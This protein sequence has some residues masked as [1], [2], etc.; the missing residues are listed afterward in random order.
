MPRIV[1]DQ[2]R[3]HA[4]A[5]RTEEGVSDGCLTRPFRHRVPWR[6]QEVEEA[7]K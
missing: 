2:Q 4:L 7:L 5:I 3:E 1:V 6:F